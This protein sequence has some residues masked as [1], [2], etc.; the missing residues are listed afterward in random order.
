MCEESD[1]AREQAAE[2]C[3]KELALEMKIAA[4]GETGHSCGFLFGVLFPAQ[5]FLRRRQQTQSQ[6]AHVAVRKNLW[7]CVT[8][9]YKF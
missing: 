9:L 5:V 7:L 1:V 2:Y 6:P 8:V 4:R 3:V